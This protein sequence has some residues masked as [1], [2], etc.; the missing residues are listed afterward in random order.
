MLSTHPLT[1][2]VAELRDALAGS[3]VLPGDDG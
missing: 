1:T 3:V 2:D